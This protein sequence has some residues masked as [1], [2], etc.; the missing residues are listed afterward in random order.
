MNLF[1][2]GE[3]CQGLTELYRDLRNTNKTEAVVQCLLVHEGSMNDGVYQT[4][5]CGP[6]VEYGRNA[7]EVLESI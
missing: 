1:A 5:T 4:D 3:P 6:R 7:D 2:H